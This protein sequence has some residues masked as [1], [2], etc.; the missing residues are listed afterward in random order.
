MV[1]RSAGG[2]AIG[3]DIVLQAGGYE[4]EGVDIAMVGNTPVDICLLGAAMA[5][6]RQ[7]AGTGV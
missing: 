5:L 6:E 1:L 2:A 7:L 3:G 4:M